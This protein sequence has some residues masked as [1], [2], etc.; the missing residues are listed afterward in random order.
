MTPL[1]S[2]HEDTRFDKLIFFH[3]ELFLLILLLLL[4]DVCAVFTKYLIF[5]LFSA[6]ILNVNKVLLIK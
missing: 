3:F 1:P 2:H 6:L 5:P 4:P